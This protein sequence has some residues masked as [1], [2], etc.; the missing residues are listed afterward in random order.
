MGMGLRRCKG[1]PNFSPH[2]FD[3]HVLM[4]PVP[5]M[6]V[7]GANLSTGKKKKKNRLSVIIAAVHLGVAAVGRQAVSE[8]P[9]M[10]LAAFVGKQP[11]CQETAAPR[12]RIHFHPLH[13]C[14][15]QARPTLLARGPPRRG[16]QPP[17]VVALAVMTAVLGIVP[18]L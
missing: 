15:R 4:P 9:I 8:Q 11:G 12:A 18:C 14:A 2:A 10:F 1:V 5:F 17:L 3:I 6:Q 13:T 16:A 7:R